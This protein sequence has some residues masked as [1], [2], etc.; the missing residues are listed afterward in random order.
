[1]TGSDAREAAVRR[2]V[3]VSGQVQGVFFRDTCRREA[4]RRGVAGWVRNCPDGT[5]EAVFEGPADGVSAMVAWSRR[6]PGQAV[7]DDV[8]VTEEPPEGADGFRV[9]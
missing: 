6:G 4:L 1:V 5:V 3:V 8:Q 2:R 9:R 7:V